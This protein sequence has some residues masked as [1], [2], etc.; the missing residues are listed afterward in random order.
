M[1]HSGA[2]DTGP[3]FAIRVP[4]STSNLGA[5]FDAVGMAVDRWLEVTARV[6]NGAAPVTIRRGGT[7]SD[8][9]CASEDDLVWRGF[10]ATC[11]ALRRTSPSGLEIDA[12]SSI[13]VARGLGS[14]AAAVVAGVLLA[15]AVFGN[16]LDH[17][18]IIDV[19]ASL[20]GH[21]DNVA[22]ATLGGA[23]L[24]VRSSGHHFVSAPLAVHPSLRFVFTVPD[25]EVRTS[26]ARAALP[27]SIEFATAVDA[28]G[29]AAALIAGLQSGDTALLEAGLDDVLHVPFRRALIRGY[30]AVT[31]AAIG[32]GAIGATLSGSGSTIVAVARSDVADA[33]LEATE[34]AW[35]SMGVGARAFVTS[36]EP[37]GATVNH[38]AVHAGTS[39]H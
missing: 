7:L 29:R 39:N 5:G 20:E 33:V 12:T 17:A 26:V 1:T 37:R 23:V 11:A 36:A 9:A 16:S 24:S 13:P 32:A 27:A 4:A 30:D 38:V 21:P 10:V 6:R 8:L 34:R 35:R 2:H 31:N 22:P 18:A 25:F 28:A 14:S 15:N 19:A 3:A